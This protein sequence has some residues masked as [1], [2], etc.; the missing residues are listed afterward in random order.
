MPAKVGFFA[1]ASDVRS[2]SQERTTLPVRQILGDLMQVQAE[3]AFVLQDR[4]AFGV[5]LHQP[6]FDAVMDHLGEMPGT[7][8]ADAAPTFIPRRCKRFENRPQ[9][10]DGRWIAADHHAVAFRKTPDAAA[11]AA[12]DVVDFLSANAAAWRSVSL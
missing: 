1:S 10:F 9:P 11:G 6:V 5:G 7:D 4:E 12:V 8:R 3:L 2:S